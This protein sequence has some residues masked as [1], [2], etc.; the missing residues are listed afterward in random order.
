MRE[1]NGLTYIVLII[2]SSAF[3]SQTADCFQTSNQ[4]KEI[5][6]DKN[7]EFRLHVSIHPIQ[8]EYSPL[9]FSEIQENLL[10]ATFAM[11]S[12]H[13]FLRTHYVSSQGDRLHPPY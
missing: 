4:Q 2:F 6:F 10:P 5:A 1:N 3:N 11:P 12:A 9:S 13:H 7:K 8:P